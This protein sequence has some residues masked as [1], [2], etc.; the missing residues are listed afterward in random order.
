MVG[1]G[2]VVN[3][4][5][6][7]IGALAGLLLKNGISE[8]YKKILMQALGLSVL[9][10]GVSG[11]LQGMFKV[12]DSGKLD[13]LYIMTMI[14]SLVIGSLIGETLNIEKGLD[15]LGKK[16]QK[17][18]S[19]A[20]GSFAE[21]FV[22]ASLVYCVGAMAIMGALEDGLLG[23]YSTLFAKSILD[24]VSAVV[25]SATLGIGVL[26]SSVPVLLYQGSITLLAGALK[27]LLTP[28]VISQI[29]LVGSVLILGI[30]LDV[31][32][33]KK[34]KVGNMLPSIFIPIIYYAITLLF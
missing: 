25:F 29:S 18:F 30:G 5:A 12:M 6:I 22:T 13:R 17:K 8:R 15:N 14:F 20:E 23:N 9:M 2:T 31:L 32:E 10:I 1:L 19:G 16:L 34:I 7:I 33:I 3:T 28:E 11:T 26:F 21:G 24:G 4:V 27:P